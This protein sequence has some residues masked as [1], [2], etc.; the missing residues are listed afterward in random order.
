MAPGELLSHSWYSRKRGGP[1]ELLLREHCRGLLLGVPAVGSAR[2]DPMSQ[3]GFGQKMI[4][5]IWFLC[6]CLLPVR[7][8]VVF[9]TMERL[10]S[11][12][13]ASFY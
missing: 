12:E 2:S 11:K 6:E 8:T 13:I 10:P 7:L 4:F 9:L 3:E 5:S 1:R